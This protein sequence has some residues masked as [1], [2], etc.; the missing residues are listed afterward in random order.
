[1]KPF[2]SSLKALHTYMLRCIRNCP[3]V[4]FFNAEPWILCVSI[5]DNR[6]KNLNKYKS[7][8]ITDTS[9]AIYHHITITSISCALYSRETIMKSCITA[10]LPIHTHPT[11]PHPLH[12][13]EAGRPTLHHWGESTHPT[14]FRGGST[15]GQWGGEQSSAPG[16]WPA[17]K[18]RVRIG[19]GGRN[20]WYLMPN[21]PWWSYHSGQNQTDQIMSS[22]L[23]HCSWHITSTFGK[24]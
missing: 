13:T 14:S 11:Y 10:I 6:N 22:G 17:T 15:P 24:G 8:I 18:G 12:T 2:I 1:M 5:P 19:T 20:T 7:P 4:C 3:G 23:A 16:K 9:C 21:E